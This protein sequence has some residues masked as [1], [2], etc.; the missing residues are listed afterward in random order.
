MA[1]MWELWRVVEGDST[2]FPV[3]ISSDETIGDLKETI[4]TKNAPRFDDKPAHELTLWAVNVASSR[5]KPFRLEDL[6]NNEKV[7]S[8]DPDNEGAEPTFQPDPT[9]RISRVF[10]TITILERKIHIFVQPPQQ[11]SSADF[12]HCKS[13]AFT[14][15]KSNYHSKFVQYIPPDIIGLEQGP[16][17][18][19]RSSGRTYMMNPTSI[20]L[21][22][23]SLLNVNSIQLDTTPLHTAPVF[24]PDRSYYIEETITATF[25][26]DVGS[27]RVLEPQ[28][29]TRVLNSH[30][31]NSGRPDLICPKQENNQELFP[32]EVKRPY[33][34]TLDDNTSLPQAYASGRDLSTGPALQANPRIYSYLWFIRQVSDD[35]NAKMDPPDKQ[36]IRKA[37]NRIGKVRKAA[38]NARKKVT[39][40]FNRPKPKKSQT[41]IMTVP[42]FENMKLIRFIGDGADTYSARW[43]GEEV[44]VKKYDVWKRPLIM[45]ELEHEASIYDMLITLQGT[46]I[47][48]MK[49]AGISDG[50]DMVLVTEDCGT[51]IRNIQPSHSDCEKIRKA[52]SEIHKSGVLHGDVRPE[53]IL[54]KEVGHVTG[55]FI[56]DFG[57]SA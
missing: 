55:V 21:W 41:E 16:D 27:V 19:G 24:Y 54:I 15:H 17:G 5:N 4:K 13:A 20:A 28:T 49:L 32:I 37:S 29:W 31:I 22:A 7:Y 47:P 11:V 40:I 8:K 36:T 23:D 48:R 50:L 2:L 39:S 18:T 57:L 56:I 42:S 45:E 52:L 26:T 46:Y 53:N 30:A 35:M 1:G 38:K 14:Q 3:N 43:Q 9:W 10:Q 51:N 25:A 12:Q 44:V 6:T 33:V 34:L